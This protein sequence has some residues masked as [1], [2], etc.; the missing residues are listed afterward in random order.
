MFGLE[1]LTLT[2]TFTI[3]YEGK[4]T[5]IISHYHKKTILLEKREKRFRCL[6]LRMLGSYCISLLDFKLFLCFSKNS[7][8]SGLHVPHSVG[9]RY[10]LKQSV[11]IEL[12]NLDFYLQS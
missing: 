11:E 9:N 7:R 6:M 1:V 12:Y 10:V 4:L 8:E 5:Y 2:I 3:R